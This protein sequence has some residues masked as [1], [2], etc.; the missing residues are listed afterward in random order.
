MFRAIGHVNSSQ[1]QEIY[2]LSLLQSGIQ[3]S[4]IVHVLSV[5][6]GLLLIPVHHVDLIEKM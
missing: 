3:V 5:C 1:F 2:I 4:F 6:W